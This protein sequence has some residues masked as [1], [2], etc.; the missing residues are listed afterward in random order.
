MMHAMRKPILVIDDSDFDAELT[1]RALSQCFVDSPVL[2]ANSGEEAFAALSDRIRHS[3]ERQVGLILLDI[4]MPGADGFELLSALK[5]NPSYA[6]IPIMIV[7]GSTIIEDAQRA[8]A[9]GAAGFITKQFDFSDFTS[10]LCTAL[11][12][13]SSS[14]Q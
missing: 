5:T 2:V 3:L 9:L 8:E 13:Y 1:L 4:K 14:L 10:S 11:K 12:P 7:S 6:A